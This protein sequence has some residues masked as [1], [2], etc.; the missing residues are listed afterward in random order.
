MTGSVQVSNSNRASFVA[1]ASPKPSA[2]PSVVPA[3]RQTVP[4][5]G[6][7]N[8]SLRVLEARLDSVEGVTSIATG[9][10]GIA[11]TGLSIASKLNPT[12]QSLDLAA[13]IGQGFEVAGTSIEAGVNMLRF[14]RNTKNDIAAHAER[15]ELHELLKDYNPALNNLD[16][17]ALTRAKELASK[18][19]GNR[20]KSSGD[21]A[22]DRFIELKRFCIGAQ[23]ATT[24]SMKIAD[25]AISPYLSIAFDSARVGD[26]GWKLANASTALSNL[27]KAVKNAGDNPALLALAKHIENE[28]IFKGRTDIFQ[29]TLSAAKVGFEVAGLVVGGPAGL[30][31]AGGVAGVVAGAVGGAMI[32]RGAAH[33]IRTDRK[34]EQAEASFASLQGQL[35]TTET[36]KKLRSDIG[37]AERAMLH[38]LRD[39]TDTQKQQAAKFLE[40]FGVKKEMIF[41]LRVMDEKDAA[42]LLTRVL[43][44][45]RVKSAGFFKNLFSA[46]NWKSF[47][48]ILGLRKR[49]H[50]SMDQMLRTLPPRS[51]QSLLISPRGSLAGNSNQA[52]VQPQQR[53]S[54]PVSV[55]DTFIGSLDD[56]DRS[57]EAEDEKFDFSKVKPDRAQSVRQPS[58]RTLNLGA[59]QRRYSSMLERELKRD[60]E[61]GQPN[62]MAAPLPLSSA[63]ASASEPAEVVGND[64][65]PI[66]DNN[67]DE[68]ELRPLFDD[69]EDRKSA[70]SSQSLTTENNNDDLGLNELFKE[71]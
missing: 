6:A 32:Y 56:K 25:A 3:S 33:A 66:S 27:R 58:P 20:L 23:E 4:P 12:N 51:S 50:R 60:L 45:D 35:G 10:V 64:I 18:D 42:I 36:T 21:A 22:L 69:I 9:L 53:G 38:M 40:D 48:Q 16:G 8:R 41:G 37:L 11:E 63:S 43:Y 13:D 5:E 31:I 62:D 68:V 15:K 30:M 71:E 54:R 7:Q 47:G 61:A 1:P 24:S 65:P 34:R 19:G 49:S 44:K 2:G 39:G 46:S 55:G 52:P 29:G 67:D 26:V 70:E 28:R 17:E 14:V 59:A 57:S